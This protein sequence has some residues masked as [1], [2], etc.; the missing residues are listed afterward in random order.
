M[1]NIPTNNIFKKL[2]KTTLL[3]FRELYFS[4]L[5]LND[6]LS[7]YHDGK[8]YQLNVICGQLR[9]ILI[10]K[11]SGNRP[12]LFQILSLIMK[13]PKVYATQEN[14]RGRPS[15][16]ITLNDLSLYNTKSSISPKKELIEYDLGEFLELTALSYEKLNISISK[17]MT[18]YSNNFGGSHY[19]QKV[20]NYIVRFSNIFI[21]D[22]N[23]LEHVIF[24]YV[25]TIKDFV[26]EVIRSTLELD[27]FVNLELNE[28]K[29]NNDVCLLNYNLKGSPNGFGLF[30]NEED[31]IK[32]KIIDSLGNTKTFKVD[33]KQYYNKRILFNLELSVD[34]KYNTN[35]KVFINNDKVTSFNIVDPFIFVNELHNN[36]F[37]INSF[38]G[39]NQDYSFKIGDLF[40]FN[41]IKNIGE[42]SDIFHHC[43]KIESFR[44]VK[45]NEIG[46]KEIGEMRF[47][48]YQ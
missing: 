28:N 39:E 15:K 24:Q 17:L 35:I 32:F 23:A 5:I 26:Y 18:D 41:E 10:E 43:K 45:R 48:F 31:Q 9:S 40:Y 3:R 12:L 11:S 38:N 42:K 1:D 29:T 8:H 34:Q 47:N 44:T 37:Y 13:K 20:P 7:H 14:D 4:A 46:K 16:L 22:Q 19:S 27:Y 6:S 36:V 25:N 2:D 21:Y 30:L 33:A